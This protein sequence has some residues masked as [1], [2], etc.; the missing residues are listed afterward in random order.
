MKDNILEV[1]DKVCLLNYYRTPY[2]VSKVVSV[3][4]TQAKLESGEK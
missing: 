1:G 2:K 4:K 3:T